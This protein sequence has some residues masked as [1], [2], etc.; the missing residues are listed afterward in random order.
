MLGAVRG[1][2]VKVVGESKTLSLND[3]AVLGLVSAGETHGFA[4]SREFGPAGSLGKIWTIPRPQVYRAITVLVAR[5]LVVETGTAP[6]AAAPTKRLV[7]VTDAGETALRE[8]LVTPVAH[9]RDA[10]SELLVKLWLLDRAGIEFSA[11]LRAQ[12]ARV[13]PMLESLR[14][15]LD[16]SEGF[17]STI[18]RWRIYSTGALAQFLDD[19]LSATSSPAMNP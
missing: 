12:A 4:V 9:V 11:L 8:W 15:Q 17:D 19:L 13:G 16:R 7:R 14:R 18:I 10:R 1:R 3:W 2:R 6:G 5:G